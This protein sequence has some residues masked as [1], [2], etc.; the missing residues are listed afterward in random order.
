MRHAL[1]GLL[2]AA[3]LGALAP[4]AAQVSFNFATPGMRISFNVPTYPNLVP[5]PGY[6]VYYAPNL[7]ANYFFYDGLYWYFDGQN[8]FESS[9]YN[10]PWYA[11]DAFDVPV[12]VLRVPVRYYRH[13]PAYFRSW[14][15]DRPPQWGSHWGADWSARRAGW[16]RWSRGTAPAPAPLP[17]YQR[18]YSGNR[19]PT[20]TE[21]QAAIQSRSYS[22]QPRDTVAQQH[23][24]QQRVHAQNAP[25]QPAPQQQRY[26][27]QQAQIERQQA[28][29]QAQFERQQERRQAQ[30]ERQEAL[31]HQTPAQRQAQAINDREQRELKRERE[32][33][34]P[35][36]SR[37]GREND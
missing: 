30:I 29:H 3:A 14:A 22:Y 18:Q 24:R 33:P 12:Y 6:P 2:T 21:Q 25:V 17:T 10:G 34:V 31:Q 1:I 36:S 28:Q 15:L 23:F 20:Q 13:P 7:N 8:W 26:E 9:W 37:A 16:D 4:A 5:I 19:Y 35:G 11:V 32:H 27:R